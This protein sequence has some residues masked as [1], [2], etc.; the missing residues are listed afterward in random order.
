M[1]LEKR[2]ILE[3]SSFGTIHVFVVDYGYCDV[4]VCG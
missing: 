4:D 3:G 2:R 1:F